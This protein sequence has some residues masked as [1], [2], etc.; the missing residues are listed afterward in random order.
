M[1]R[2][3]RVALGIAAAA[4]LFLGGWW[5]AS[6]VMESPDDPLA[7]ADPTLFTVDEGLV[8]RSLRFAAV[9]EWTF[10]DLARNA[11]TGVVTSVG[12]AP[13]ATISFGDVLYTVDLRPVAAAEGTVPAFRDMALRV[14]GED[15]AQLQRLLAQLEFYQGE[16]DGEFDSS[17]RGAVRAWQE[18]LGVADDG[19]VRVGDIVFVPDLPA[20]VVL[21]E[22]VKVGATLVGGELAVRRVSAEVRFWIP[23]SP[24]QRNLV[25]LSASVMVTHG[26]GVWE[27]T[28]V[29]AI[30][31]EAQGE[32]RLILE[33]RDGGSVCGSE[34]GEVSLE[35]QT[36]FPSEIV[37]VPETTGP[38]VPVAA[39]ETL[40]DGGTVVTADDGSQIPV[41]ILAAADGLAVVDGLEVG[42]VIMLPVESDES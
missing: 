4:L 41:D 12:V 8:G 13:G 6:V 22:D 34:C 19:V 17:T 1:K 23:L 40:P 14:E 18:S 32:L 9:A 3:V 16:A 7:S 37:V 15:V 25:P 28:I 38:V 42:D 27:A 36:S 31:D 20:R 21:S 24:E 26:Q 30:E 29:E 11:T 39:I 35:G 10:Q 2:A 33:S 5:A